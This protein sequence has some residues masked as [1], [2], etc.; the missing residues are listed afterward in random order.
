MLIVVHLAR[1]AFPVIVVAG[2]VKP[3]RSILG[4]WLRVI[5]ETPPNV[6]NRPRILANMHRDSSTQ[7]PTVKPSTKCKI[8]NADLGKGIVELNEIG[9]GSG[10]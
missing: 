10:D 5:R 1:T 3:M 2:N 7:H 4:E 9:R 8:R 6:L